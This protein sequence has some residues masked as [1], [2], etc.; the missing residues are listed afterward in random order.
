MRP[1]TSLRI[2]AKHGYINPLIIYKTNCVVGE[3]NSFAITLLSKPGR[4]VL[5]RTETTPPK[6]SKLLYTCLARNNQLV[7][8]ATQSHFQT[9]RREHT[10]PEKVARQKGKTLLHCSGGVEMSRLSLLISHVIIM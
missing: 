5:N 4:L 3:K 8:K 2:E 10:T 7:G 6:P 9:E 1:L